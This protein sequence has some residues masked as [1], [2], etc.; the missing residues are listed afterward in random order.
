MQRTI[1]GSPGRALGNASPLLGT[2]LRA[3]A[4]P[5]DLVADEGPDDPRS[6]DHHIG[7]LGHL[8]DRPDHVVLSLGIPFQLDQTTGLR[9]LHELEEAAVSEGLLANSGSLLRS[10]FFSEEGGRRFGSPSRLRRCERLECIVLAA[11]V[12]GSPQGPFG[13]ALRQF[14]H[15]TLLEMAKQLAKAADP[16]V[17]LREGGVLAEDGPFQRRGE[18]RTAGRPLQGERLGHQ[19]AQIGGGRLAVSALTTSSTGCALRR[20]GVTAWGSRVST[21]LERVV[22][23]NSSQDG[24][25]RSEVEPRMPTPMTRL[26]SS[27]SLWTSGVKSLSPCRAQGGRRSRSNAARGVNRHLDVGGVLPARPHPLWDLDQLDVAPSQ[28]PPVFAP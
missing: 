15:L 2:T 18:H 6:N 20:R 28:H 25:S 21:P 27:R 23:R 5:G 8:S 17:R 26:L 7:S 22:K 10:R 3:A 11:A 9:C 19:R 12:L 16:V 13:A 14:D 1:E 4:T 24:G